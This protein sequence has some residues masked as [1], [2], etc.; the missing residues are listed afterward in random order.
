MKT[1]T[2]D[3]YISENSSANTAACLSYAL[4]HAAVF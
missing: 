1:E 2:E 4:N 3:L